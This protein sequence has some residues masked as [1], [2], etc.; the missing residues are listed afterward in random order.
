MTELEP[1]FLLELADEIVGSYLPGGTPVIHASPTQ[2]VTPDI[3]SAHEAAHRTLCELSS[4]GLYF[5]GLVLIH[6]RAKDAHARDEARTVLNRTI[7]DC[8]IVQEGYATFCQIQQSLISGRHDLADPQSYLPPTYLHAYSQFLLNLGDVEEFLRKYGV[9]DSNAESFHKLALMAVETYADVLAL[10]AMAIP[11]AEIM[12]LHSF[13]S[14]DLACHIRQHAPDKRL[15][16]LRARVTFPFI[17]HA[18]VERCRALGIEEPANPSRPLNDSTNELARHLCHIAGLPYECSDR[19]PLQRMLVDA[20]SDDGEPW[21]VRI[22]SADKM[23]EYNGDELIVGGPNLLATG[24]PVQAAQV[25]LGAVTNQWGIEQPDLVCELLP[26]ENGSLNLLA[27]VHAFVSTTEFLDHVSNRANVDPTAMQIYR[28]MPPTTAIRIGLVQMQVHASQCAA[29]LNA[30]PYRSWSWIL[31]EEQLL[32]REWSKWS[33]QELIGNHPVFLYRFTV[34]LDDPALPVACA[35]VPPAP[36]V[37]KV[38]SAKVDNGVIVEKGIAI[39]GAELLGGFPNDIALL[40]YPSPPNRP[41]TTPVRIVARRHIP[42]NLPNL[43]AYANSCI[44]HC[45]FYGL[46]SSLRQAATNKR[47]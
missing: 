33:E 43:T 29:L 21:E 1:G 4:L 10:A 24:L 36:A 40:M 38:F 19:F 15:Q 26:I 3:V 32:G 37:G 17:I 22:P 2:I 27:F 6:G 47:I 44:A 9:D 23:R 25:A 39:G 8:W 41:N 35:H 12:G 28:Q 31:G 45:V 7:T 14:Y 16:V 20:G 30:F 46:Y 34:D 5:K 11:M 18:W 42:E 13:T